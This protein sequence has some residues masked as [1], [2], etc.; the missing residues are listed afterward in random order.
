MMRREKEFN[1]NTFQGSETTKSSLK[2]CVQGSE[3]TKSSLKL[4]VCVCGGSGF[5]SKYS[6]S[7]CHEVWD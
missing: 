3:T 4:C 7:G 5:Q 1:I 2:L 6:W